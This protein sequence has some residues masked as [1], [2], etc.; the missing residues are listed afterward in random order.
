[1]NYILQVSRATLGKATWLFLCLCMLNLSAFAQQTVSGK[2]TDKTGEG[3]QGVTVR[4][5]GTTTGTITDIDG[6]FTL[7]APEDAI[8]EVSSV[9]FTT[10]LIPVNGQSTIDL[11]L[12]ED[13]SELEEVV[14]IG[15]GTQKKSHL[16]GV[17]PNPVQY[18]LKLKYPEFENLQVLVE[19]FDIAG[20]KV[21][22]SIEQAENQR[23]TLGA[24]SLPPGNY[25]I[26]SKVGTGAKWQPIDKV[27]RFVRN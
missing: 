16:T 19:V 4:V 9:G 27:W 6:N 1:M 12:E 14:V 13:V 7:S 20:S 11:L 22:Q 3:L 17:Y 18:E 10:Q 25:F 5:Q 8:L 21:F 26:R 2:I 24:E 23:I 15:Y